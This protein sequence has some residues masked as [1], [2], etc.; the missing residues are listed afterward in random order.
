MKLILELLL[1]F[2]TVSCAQ[3]VGP[4]GPSGTAGAKGAAG[5][6]CSVLQTP[7]GATVA[8]T[9]GSYATLTNGSQGL[10]GERGAPGQNGTDATPITIVQ[11]CPNVVPTY[12]GVFPE[13]AVC[14]GGHLFGTYNGNTAYQYF[15]E[16]PDGAYSSSGQGAAC[17]FTL[18]G[19]EISY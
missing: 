12:A 4:A 18:T 17:T 6:G 16:L 8:C 14:L 1:M 2:L 9:D 10:Q 3:K 19:C 15:S 11:L 7:S 5:V 13:V